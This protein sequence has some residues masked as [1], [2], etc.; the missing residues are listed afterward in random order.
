[1]PLASFIYLLL[2]QQLTCRWL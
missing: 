2:W 1:M